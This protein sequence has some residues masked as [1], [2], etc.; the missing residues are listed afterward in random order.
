MAVVEL[1][2]TPL[3]AHVRT[4]RL[5]AAAIARRA[6]VQPDVLDEIRLAVGEACSRAVQLHQSCGDVTPVRLSLS[7]HSGHFD[8]T[9]VDSVAAAA[10][11]LDFDI[12]LDVAANGDSDDLLP[13]DIG[14][15]VIMGLVDDVEVV[16]LPTGTE[17]RMS[18]P[19]GAVTRD[20]V[21]ATGA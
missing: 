14:L 13:P 17:I 15:A 4:A 8:V 3:P 12:D 7:V 21:L 6:D 2:F 16:V 9:V 11:P 5:I 1:S 18:W 19:S 20:G 10:R